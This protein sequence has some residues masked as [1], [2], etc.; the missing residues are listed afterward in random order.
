MTMKV[1]WIISFSYSSTHSVTPHALCI[2]MFRHRKKVITQ[3]NFGCFSIERFHASNAAYQ[4]KSSISIESDLNLKNSLEGSLH[5]A[6]F[7]HCILTDV[8][9]V[10]FVFSQRTVSRFC[11]AV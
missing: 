7:V 10:I 2:E 8:P 4:T 6:S 9:S 11:L 5:F 1:M 3:N